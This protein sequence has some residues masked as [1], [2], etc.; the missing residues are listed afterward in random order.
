MKQKWGRRKTSFLWWASHLTRNSSSLSIPVG[1]T[2]GLNPAP[3]H[4]RHTKQQPTRPL[5]IARPSTDRLPPDSHALL[6][7]PVHQLDDSADLGSRT[8]LDLRNDRR[9]HALPR[10]RGLRVPPPTQRT[11]RHCAVCSQPRSSPSRPWPRSTA[12][13]NLRTSANHRAHS[14]AVIRSDERARASSHVHER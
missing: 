6:P 8:R 14:Q 10:Q 4:P 5:P 2:T 1:H 9:R 7:A 12:C 3:L 11:Q 13:Y